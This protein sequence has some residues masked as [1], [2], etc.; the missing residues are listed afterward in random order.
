MV[1]RHRLQYRF[2]ARY[3]D[4]FS[5]SDE[6]FQTQLHFLLG[7]SS[8]FKWLFVSWQVIIHIGQIEIDKHLKF[9][10]G[11]SMSINFILLQKSER[12]FDVEVVGK[13]FLERRLCHLGCLYSAEFSQNFVPK[14]ICIPEL[15]GGQT[16][17]LAKTSKT[18][19]S[20][21]VLDLLIARTTIIMNP[22]IWG[23]QTHTPFA[24]R[25]SQVPL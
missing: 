3:G 4:V 19:R 1:T 7:N 18:R 21:T 5:C 16:V 15:L 17:E 23:H 10:S 24:L 14:T 2:T 12:P 6:G 8:E 9:K 25:H 11:V 22:C 20:S 13:W